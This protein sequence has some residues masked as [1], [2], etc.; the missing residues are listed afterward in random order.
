MLGSS[1]SENISHPTISDIYQER[2][3]NDLS[4]IS[5][6]FHLHWDNVGTFVVGADAI[7]PFQSKILGYLPLGLG[8]HIDKISGYVTSI[9]F[10][11][12]FR[13]F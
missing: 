6:R 13:Y 3:A 1:S 2:C 11:S 8:L 9:Y 7:F 12:C 4:D 5:V 10:Y